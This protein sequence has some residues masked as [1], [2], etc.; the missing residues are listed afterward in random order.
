MLVKMLQAKVK[1]FKSKALN[2]QIL[3]LQ[4]LH[5]GERVLSSCR[6]HSD[7][8]QLVLLPSSCQPRQVD[9]AVDVAG[10]RLESVAVVGHR[11]GRVGGVRR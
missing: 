7:S 6:C 9:A 5:F 1:H 11:R 2:T 3:R 10:G 8:C 4:S